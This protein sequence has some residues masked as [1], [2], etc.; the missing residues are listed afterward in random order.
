MARAKRAR[1]VVI[2]NRNRQTMEAR[3]VFS[4]LLGKDPTTKLHLQP[5]ACIKTN[6]QNL[7]VVT[8]QRMNGSIKIRRQVR[9]LLHYR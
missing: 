8:M 3:S 4:M 5:L 6:K 1:S 9:K 7:T 2:G